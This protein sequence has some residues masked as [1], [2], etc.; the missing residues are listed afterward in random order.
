MLD[1]MDNHSAHDVFPLLFSPYSCE[2]FSVSAAAT[3]LLNMMY[4]FQPA[5]WYEWY[6]PS[7]TGALERREERAPVPYFVL[8]DGRL[9][10]SCSVGPADGRCV[11][12]TTVSIVRGTGSKMA[13]SCC[14]P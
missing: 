3:H 14:L 9:Q 4:H 7:V 1:Q 2:L 12:S 6:E 10:A 13:F 5:E 8:L 11:K